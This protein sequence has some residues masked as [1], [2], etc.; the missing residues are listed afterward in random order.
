MN[1]HMRNGTSLRAIHNK[2]RAESRRA[3]TRTQNGTRTQASPVQVI[4]NGFTDRFWLG[5]RVLRLGL[6]LELEEGLFL[7]RGKL[8][9]YRILTYTKFQELF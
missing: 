2:I 7:Q 8:G 3:R 4:P 5:A 1:A 6:H 9:F